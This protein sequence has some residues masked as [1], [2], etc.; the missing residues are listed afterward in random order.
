MLYE[1]LSVAAKSHPTHPAIIERDG[2]LTCKELLDLTDSFAS[3]L[4]SRGLQPGDAVALLLPNHHE[5]V[6]GTLALAKLGAIIVPLNPQYQRR[7]LKFYLEDSAARLIVA[8]PSHGELCRGMLVELSR[9]CGLITDA[10][11]ASRGAHRADRPARAPIGGGGLCQ[12]STGSTGTPKRVVRTQANL[13]S[14]ANSF[15][16]TVGTAHEDRILSVAP[17]FHSHGFGN[18]ILAAMQV[19]ASMVVLESFNRRRV[20]E[21]LKDQRATVFPGMPFMFSILADAPSIANT[22]LPGLRLAFSAGAPLGKDTFDKFAHKFGVEIR[23]LYGSTETGA[24]SI[25]R[26]STEGNLWASVGRPLRDVAVRVVNEQGEDAEP[27]EIG[28]IRGTKAG[29]TAHKSN[30]LGLN[31][32]KTRARLRVRGCAHGDIPPF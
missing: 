2:S 13:L 17:F 31:D 26:G 29:G 10:K 20:M 12:Y 25:N 15:R 14:E 7:E 30:T 3:Y 1:L 4:S 22:E 8:A 32:Y 23:Q 11:N 16:A 6:I 9:D 24:I 18:C 19:G 27:G 28:K 5:F 21:A